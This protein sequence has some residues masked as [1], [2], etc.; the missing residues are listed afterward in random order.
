MKTADISVTVD[1]QAEADILLLKGE[2]S[3]K[4][5]E[6][7]MKQAEEEAKPV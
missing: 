2:E 3:L 1:P 7:L 4:R 6:E 5:A